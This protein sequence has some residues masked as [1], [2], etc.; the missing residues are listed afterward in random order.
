M[1]LTNIL[2]NQRP[3]I[4]MNILNLPFKKNLMKQTSVLT[5]IL[6]LFVTL[7]IFATGCGSSS[8]Q[9]STGSNTPPPRSMINTE[10]EGQLVVNESHGNSSSP[11]ATP[12]DAG[13]PPSTS[14]PMTSKQLKGAEDILETVSDKGV[15]AIDAKFIFKLHC[16]VCHGFKGDAKVNGATDLTKS[17]IS[18]VESVAHIN[19]G[20]GLMTP[21]YVLL[22]KEEIVAVA[23]Y[24]ATLR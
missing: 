1:F 22:S 20:R 4:V 9:E 5:V 19:Y 10:S 8:A 15:N 3:L 12:E 24:S 13:N 17:K 6:F 21:Y 16:A 11:A 23:R 14:P 18:L 7:A 2:H